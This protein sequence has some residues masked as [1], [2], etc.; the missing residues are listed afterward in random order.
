MNGSSL[1]NVSVLPGR[2]FFAAR[3]S[4]RRIASLTI[5]TVASVD[6]FSFFA[7]PDGAAVD[8]T[9][10]DG[11]DDDVAGV[12]AEAALTA[13]TIAPEIES[14]RAVVCG[15]PV[16]KWKRIGIAKSSC[17]ALWRQFT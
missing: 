17:T 1:P 10:A 16:N 3:A 14:Q 9:P 12:C 2:A 6:F 5:S 4:E 13:I 7:V 11:A 8:E 15:A